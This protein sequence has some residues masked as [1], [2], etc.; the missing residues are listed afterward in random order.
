MAEPAFYD[1]PQHV[2]EQSMHYEEIKK[3]LAE[4]YH[5]WEE[6]ALRIEAIEEELSQ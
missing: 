1:D 4:S 6:Y 2:K 3:K 5:K